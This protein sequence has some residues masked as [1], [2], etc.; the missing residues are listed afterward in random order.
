MNLFVNL[1]VCYRYERQWW[2]CQRQSKADH[3]RIDTLIPSRCNEGPKMNSYV[4]AFEC[5]RIINQ[6]IN[7][8]SA[9][10]ETWPAL[11]K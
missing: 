7:T 8:E 4:K 10:T 1:N 11:Y 3:P 5:Y 9:Y 2:K 6:S